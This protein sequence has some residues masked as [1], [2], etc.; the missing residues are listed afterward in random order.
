MLQ[1]ANRHPPLH[2]PAPYRG[3]NGREVRLL[4]RGSLRHL[5]GR[6]H[7]RALRA[8]EH[9]WPKIHRHNSTTVPSDITEY[10]RGNSIQRPEHER[11]VELSDEY[12]G[13][14]GYANATV[15]QSDCIG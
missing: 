13:S 14:V 3:N 7:R 6:S 2:Q 8:F 5:K 11:G 12:E 4:D 15:D 9:R 1:R 10:Q